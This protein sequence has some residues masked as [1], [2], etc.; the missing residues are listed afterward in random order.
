MP[1]ALTA[2]AQG[3]YGVFS[4]NGQGDVFLLGEPFWDCPPFDLFPPP[5][6]TIGAEIITVCSCAQEAV[7]SVSAPAIA[8]GC[9]S[10]EVYMR[11]SLI[12][13]LVLAVFAALIIDGRLMRSYREANGSAVV[14][15]LGY[16]ED[17]A[18]VRNLTS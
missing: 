11:R 9:L 3:E 10:C 2:L 18:A 15:H 7:P 16:C 8:V 6:P 13:G 17:Y 14:N 4:V 1:D 12:A 5:W